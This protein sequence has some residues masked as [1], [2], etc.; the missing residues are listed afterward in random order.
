MPTLFRDYETRSTLNLKLCGAHKYAS[1]PTTDVWCCAYAI[2]E[3]PV[4]LW[5][6]RHPVPAEF[7]EAANN[8]DWIVSAFN[9]SFERAIEQHVMG[10]RYS[11]PII[12]LDRHR[13]S[14]AAAQALALPASLKAVAKALEIAEQKD[15][16]GQ[17]LMIQMSRPRHPRKGENPV[18]TYWFDDEE[19]RSRLY[20][21]C[22]R[23]V[24]TERAVHKRIGHLPDDEQA[25]WLVD[26]LINDRGIHRSQARCRRGQGR[27]GGA[28]AY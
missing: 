23:D 3:G 5:L 28:G 19:R 12:P 18:G 10:S 14:Q 15:E 2:D 13:C 9:D 21:Y 4:Q 22:R 7:I 20:D 1:H 11:F 25:V 24:L 26:A 17:R 6:P 8:P 27:R 16:S